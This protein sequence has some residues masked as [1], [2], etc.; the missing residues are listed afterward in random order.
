MWSAEALRRGKRPRHRHVLAEE[1][2][3]VAQLAEPHAQACLDRLLEQLV[4]PTWPAPAPSSRP[5][6]RVLTAT[7][8]AVSVRRRSE[9]SW[10]RC[11]DVRLPHAGKRLIRVPASVPAALLPQHMPAAARRGASTNKL[12]SYVVSRC[13]CCANSARPA[14]R[15]L[16]CWSLQNGRR[17][18]SG[19]CNCINARSWFVQLFVQ[20]V[21]LKS[22][23]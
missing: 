5:A 16:L 23:F 15:V 20:C 9:A 21:Q 10:P 17:V 11:A 4:P 22:I 19:Y 7:F 6:I 8:A 14:G 18:P 2:T 12:R 13:P 1:W 3:L